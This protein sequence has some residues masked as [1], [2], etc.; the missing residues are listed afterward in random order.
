MHTG[1]KKPPRRRRRKP[2]AKWDRICDF[3]RIHY[4]SGLVRN[5]RPQSVFLVARPGEG[6]TEMLD[7]FRCNTQVDFYTDVT[8]QK[9]IPVYRRALRG[10]VTHICVT[11]FQK[12][13]ARRRAVSGNTLLLML[14]GMEDGVFKI[15]YGPQEYDLGGAR[16]GLVAATTPRSI[17][18]N[19][20]LITEYAIDSRAFFIDAELP[21]HEIHEIEDRIVDGDQQ[22]LAP[23]VIPYHKHITDVEVPK[24]LGKK[25]QGWVK[26]MRD[27]KLRTY[28][29]RTLTRF[30]HLLRGVAYL[31]ARKKVIV[32]DL[33]QLYALSDFWLQPPELPGDMGSEKAQYMDGS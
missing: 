17:E 25:V 6:K 32:A 19:P 15:A 8:F 18:R 20:Y 3:V 5:A 33:D 23:I 2:L 12:L 29:M 21:M 24:S 7:R 22:A 4:A 13:I 27:R 10:Q 26:E 31:N 30:L 16:L 1:R 14:Q 28:G 11:E 9:L